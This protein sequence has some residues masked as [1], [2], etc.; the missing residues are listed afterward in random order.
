[1]NN[2]IIIRKTKSACPHCLAILDAFVIENEGKVFLSRKCLK[3]GEFK[4]LLSNYPEFYKKLDKFYFSIV[5][6]KSS[7]REY[8]IWPTLRCNINCSI[9][10][11]EKTKKDEKQSEPTL[12]VIEDFIKKCSTPFFTLSG[13]EPTCRSDLNKI[14]GI[15]KKY[16]KTVAMNTNGLKL[17][18]LDYVT[19]LQAAGIDR[20]NVQFDG[21]NRNTYLVFRGDDLLEIKLKILKNLKILNIPTVLNATIA[22]N[23]NEEAILELIE[24]AAKNHFI[25][26]ITFFTICNIG[27][28]RKWNLDNYI[29]PDEVVDII[30]HQTR[31]RINR[32]SICLFQ[33]LHLTVKSFFSQKAC[34]YNRVFVLLREKDNFKAIDKF[35]NLKKMEP[36]LDIYQKLYEKN[37]FLAKLLFLFLFPIFLLINS[38][39]LILK[40]FIIMAFSYFLKTKHYLNT[41][42]F[43]YISLST[44]CDPY[45]I[46][47]DIVKNCQNEIIWVEDASGKF[48]HKGSIC[49]YQ[50]GLE[51]PLYE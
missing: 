40:E 30:E 33:K 20:I 8:E 4:I 39:P 42:K 23:V 17:A 36:I 27:N 49:L 45:K 19:S 32:E 24:Y 38:S 21:F 47:Y 28:A 41:T 2:K 34:L 44:G 6:G 15:L 11:F 13:G 22:K 43:F 46:D 25:N 16:N 31:Q 26:G 37:K 12:Q 29:I 48:T 7:V 51:R 18:N 35:I 50:M 10:C 1:M 5:N 3:H 14:I 9:C